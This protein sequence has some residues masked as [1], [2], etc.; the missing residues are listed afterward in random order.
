MN[1]IGDS[2]RSLNRIQSRKKFKTCDVE[3]ET[4][5]V[6]FLEIDGFIE[7]IVHLKEKATPFADFKERCRQPNREKALLSRHGV[8]ELIGNRP[9]QYSS[10]CQSGTQ[11][12]VLSVWVYGSGLDSQ[13]PCLGDAI[14]MVGILKKFFKLVLPNCLKHFLPCETRGYLTWNYLTY[15]SLGHN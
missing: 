10:T 13:V 11:Y 14:V 12:R 9:V 1:G 4:L 8:V 2:S 7:S 5:R 3:K 6:V 15:P